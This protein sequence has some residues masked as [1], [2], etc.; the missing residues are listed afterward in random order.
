M[1]R[2]FYVLFF[3]TCLGLINCGFAEEQKVPNAISSNPG[4]VN[5][6]TGTGALGEA[7]GLK[8]D[9]GI[10]LGGLWIGDLNYLF[11]GGA[12]PKKWSGN[13]LFQLS[14][15]LDT[16]KL[17]GWKGGLFNVEFFQFNGRPTNAEAGCVQ[18]YNSLTSTPPRDRSELY[19]IWFRQELFQKR[20]IIRIGK[21]VQNYDFNNIIKPIPLTEA[22]LSIPA[23]TGLTYTPI[24]VIPTL[25]GVLPGYYNTAFGLT[26]TY[27]PTETSYLTYGVYDGNLARGKQLGLR[28]PQF[29]GYYFHIAEAGCSWN[30]G[31]IKHPGNVGIG[32]WNQ[33][34]KLSAK[35]ITERGAR[36]MYLFGTQR[37]WRRNPGVDNSGIIG[38]FQFGLNR[39]ST[40]PFRQYFGTGLTFLGLIPGRLSD[41]VGIG[42]AWSKLN[43]HLFKRRN[44]VLLQG[45]YQMFLFSDAYFESALSYIP[46]PGAAADL[47]PALAATARIIT[48]F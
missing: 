20:L 44:E 27:L 22:G 2:N 17:N 6:Q 8:K 43:K 18:G 12:K 33:T 34:G 1:D 15:S 7:F 9:S 26:L 45:Y 10:R 13:N 42:V 48:L 11:C 23:T 46:K 30:I 19:Q 4:T 36:G 3:L 21:T 37:L 32:V 29:N 24:Y 5:I 41:S 40:L 38:L 47:K 25:L 28:G 39:S 16:E 14:L 31:K 35:S